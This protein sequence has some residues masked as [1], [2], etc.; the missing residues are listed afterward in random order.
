[1]FSLEFCHQKGKGSV[2]FPAC[3]T[4]DEEAHFATVSAYKHSGFCPTRSETLASFF[5]FAFKRL[6]INRTYQRHMVIQLFLDREAV[7][8][9]IIL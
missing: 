4:S 2:Q 1:M 5:H 3:N 7:S 9:D 6:N 8:T